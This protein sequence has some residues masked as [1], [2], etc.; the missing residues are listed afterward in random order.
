LGMRS[1]GTD[2]RP[3]ENSPNTALESGPGYWPILLGV[4]QIMSTTFR[5]FQSISSL[6]RLFSW[7]VLGCVRACHARGPS[8]VTV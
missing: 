8:Y 7:H 6:L 2:K 3:S 5:T 4:A 1:P